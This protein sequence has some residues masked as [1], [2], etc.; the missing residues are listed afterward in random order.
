MTSPIRLKHPHQARSTFT[1]CSL[2][3]ERIISLYGYVNSYSTIDAK[4]SP[5]C[6][7]KSLLVPNRFQAVREILRASLQQSKRLDQDANQD[8]GC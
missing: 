4:T 3:I 5:V 1:A 7:F 8:N 2:R 6:W